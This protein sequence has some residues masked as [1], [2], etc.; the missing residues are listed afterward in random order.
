MATP[1]K[2]LGPPAKRIRAERTG[3]N[4]WSLYEETFAVPS[5]V[6]LLVEKRTKA[7]IQLRI[8]DYNAARNGP[9]GYGDSGVE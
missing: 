7:T 6:K 1:K 3:P 9:N 4:E 5:E 2:Y 8:K